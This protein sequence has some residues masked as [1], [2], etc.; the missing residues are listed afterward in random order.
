MM[1]RPSIPNPSVGSFSTPKT[2]NTITLHTLHGMPS[3]HVTGPSPRRP[4][5]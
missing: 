4:A 3:A 1:D 2:Q 5:H